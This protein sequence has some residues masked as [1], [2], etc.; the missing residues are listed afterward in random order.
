[1]VFYIVLYT[2]LF[3][4]SIPLIY[5]II[6]SKNQVFRLKRIFFIFLTAKFLFDF[7][8]F[9]FQKMFGNAMPIFHVSVFV[10][11][12]LIITVLRNI[13]YFSFSKWFL[14]I[15]VTLSILDITV[16]SSFFSSNAISS[17]FIFGFIIF[18]CGKIMNLQKLSKV[19]EIFSSTLF[20]YY[21]V[22]LTFTVF[23][24]FQ[25]STTLVKDFAFY[26]FAFATFAY[27]VSLTKVLCI[28][29]KK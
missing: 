1:M 7:L 5:L 2:A 24:K 27:N 12:I 22:A 18:Y 14:L 13:Q 10:E 6:N 21:I 8:V 23:Q 25:L 16:F 19:H 17:I 15:G 20:L 9:I 29:K 3:S 11:F 26:F 4:S 28:M